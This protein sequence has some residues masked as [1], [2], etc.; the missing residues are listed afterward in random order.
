MPKV[1]GLNGGDANGGSIADLDA[2]KQEIIREMKQE[3]SRLKQDLIN[4]ESL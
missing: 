4:G 2:L 3:M 1:N